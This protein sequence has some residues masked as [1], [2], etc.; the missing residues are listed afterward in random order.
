MSLGWLRDKNKWYYLY[1][2]GS[3]ATGVISVKEKEYHLRSDGSLI[4][5]DKDGAVV[6]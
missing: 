5:T 4:V 3:M 2:D 6:E 1:E